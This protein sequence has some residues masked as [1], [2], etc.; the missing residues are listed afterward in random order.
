MLDAGFDAVYDDSGYDT[1]KHLMEGVA[2]ANDLE[3]AEAALGPF[4]FDC[5]LRYVENHDEER[6]A[7]PH[8]WGGLGMEAGRPAATSLF[9]LSRGPVM[10]YHGQEVG[11]PGL[12]EEGFGG[13][14]QRT[15]IFDY[16]SLPELNK[17]W[18]YG[19]ADGAALS[20]DQKR[21]RH[22]YSR[23]LRLLS[24]PAFARGNT[25]FLNAVNRN[26]PFFGKVSDMGSSGHWLQAFLRSDP[27]AD[28]HYLVTVNFHPNTALRHLRIHL[29]EAAISALRLHENQNKWLIL[30]DHLLYQTHNR[31]HS[32]L[33]TYFL[34]E[35]I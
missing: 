6:L 18:N 35:F 32:E 14:D 20:A 2:W 29:S 10:V 8:S 22:W 24:E 21:L 9:A 12:G 17:W 25:I 33:V 16:W 28:S 30:Q 5:G 7:H 13:D 15:T 3:A 11:E 31:R 19:A 26:N 4:F 34:K 27:Q 23:L 1:V